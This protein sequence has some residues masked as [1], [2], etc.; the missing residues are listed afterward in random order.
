MTRTWPEPAPPQVAGP[1]EVLT[2]RPHRQRNADD[3]QVAAGEL[4]RRLAR[5]V[6]DAGDPA[7]AAGRRGEAAEAA[8]LVADRQLD[9]TAAAVALSVTA[10]AAGLG[11]TAAEAVIHAALRSGA[12]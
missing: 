8:V 1:S 11:L 9:R 3:P 4:L 5:H 7:A 2:T 10:Q 12:R 6:L